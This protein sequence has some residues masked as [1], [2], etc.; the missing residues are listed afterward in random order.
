MATVNLGRVRPE[1]SVYEDTSESYRLSIHNG[2]KEIITPNLRDGGYIKE[3]GSEINPA[4]AVSLISRGSRTLTIADSAVLADDTGQGIEYALT[5][6]NTDNPQDWVT[7]GGGEV[8]WTGLMPNTGYY[9][10]ARSKESATLTAGAVRTGGLVTTDRLSLPEQLNQDWEEFIDAFIIQS[11]IGTPYN[12]LFE[13]GPVHGKGND[14]FVGGV[15]L[16]N[17][18]VLLVPFFS[19]NV[20]IYDIATNTYTDGPVH[21]KGNDAFQGGVLLPNNKV[22]LVPYN[23]ANVGIL[24]VP[25]IER[26]LALCLS[27]FINK[28]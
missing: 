17:N 4:W 11:R 2:V 20:G 26:N 15:L 24:S 3:A 12:P 13:S 22:L 18:K 25:G 14:A 19:A 16:P 23:S 5:I 7:G 9:V 28:F 8:I 21:G 27:P 6:S 1:I 10:W